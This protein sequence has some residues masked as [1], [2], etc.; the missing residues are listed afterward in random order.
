MNR[1]HRKI[2]EIKNHTQGYISKKNKEDP[3]MNRSTLKH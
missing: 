1:K 2:I 3:L